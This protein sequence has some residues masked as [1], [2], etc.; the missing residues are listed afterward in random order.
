M[1]FNDIREFIAKCEELG[2][3][4]Q[5]KQE[6]DWNLEAGAITRRCCEQSGP[7]PLFQKVKD[8]PNGYRIWGAPLATFRRL[9]IAMDLDPDASFRQI[10]DAYI[11]GS[12]QPVKPRVVKEGPCKQNMMMGDDV[13]LYKFPAPLIHD[14]D[15]G[16]YLSTFHIIAT[17]D[18]GSDWVNWG[19][20]RQMIHTKNTLGGLMAPA[21]HIGMMFRNKYEAM[22]KPMEFAVAIGTEPITALVGGAGCPAGVNEVDIIGGIRK[23]PLDIIKCETVDLYVPATSEIVI[24][25]VVNPH[26]RKMEGPFGEYGGY[27]SIPNL[28]RPVFTVKA[29]TYRDDP[30]LTMSNMGTPVDD[31]DIIQGMTMAAEIFITLKKMGFPI[32]GV[33]TPPECSCSTVVISTKVP[34]TNIA[35]R[36]AGGVWASAVGHFV[37]KIIIV[38]DDVDPTNM[39]EVLH[40]WST[41]CHPIRGTTIIPQAVMTPAYPYYSPE[42]SRYNQGCNVYYDCTWPKRWPKE[43]IAV[44]SSFRDIYP[45]GIQEK[46]LANWKNYGF[47]E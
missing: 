22:N 34:Y 23:E 41:K 5:V 31:A 29:I 33:Y 28:P 18:P 4:V 27:R 14:G 21:Q 38:D 35:S 45:K 1:P 46:V 7:A 8:Y 42:E 40:A 16:R 37:V 6:V 20:Y 36:I 19:M 32:T 10:M 17:K 9:A 44:R 43:H 24:E 13:D 39:R 3:A 12:A 25:G 26:E 30:I 47:K 2:D 15:G 11:Q